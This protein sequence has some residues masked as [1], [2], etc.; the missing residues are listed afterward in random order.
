MGEQVKERNKRRVETGVVSSDKR[1]KT[2]S[3]EV[4][5]LFKTPKYG[6][7]VNRTTRYHAHDEKNEARVGDTVEITETR[8]LSKLKRWRLVKIIK[9]A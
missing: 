9:R 6:K 4:K 1:E 7:Y 2:I 3:V 5:W 8:P